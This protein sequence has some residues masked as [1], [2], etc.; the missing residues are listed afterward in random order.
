MIINLRGKGS[1]VQHYNGAVG[2]LK[3][4]ACHKREPYI[5]SVRFDRHLCVHNFNSRAVLQKVKTCMYW[6]KSG[7]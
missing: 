5:V 1:V 4:I 7:M 6:V 3:S 2:S